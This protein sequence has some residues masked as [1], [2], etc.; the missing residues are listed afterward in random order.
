M[1]DK[2]NMII[3]FVVIVVGIFV[4]SYKTQENFGRNGIEIMRLGNVRYDLKGQELHTRRLN[5]CYYDK[6]ICYDNTFGNTEQN[7]GAN[8]RSMTS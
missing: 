5:S 3:L 7:T 6:R 4:F 8:Y 1:C 2:K